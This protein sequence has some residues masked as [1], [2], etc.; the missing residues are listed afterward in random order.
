M[1]IALAYQIDQAHRRSFL[2]ER[3]L[4][5]E[6][7]RSEHL[8]HALLPSGIA[9]QLKETDDYIAEVVP[10]ATVAFADL[11]GFTALSERLTAQE[12]IKILT[13]M[14]STLDEA[15]A[16]H[17]LEKI[18][19]IGDAYMVS[20]GVADAVQQDARAVAAFALETVRIIQEYAHETGLP[21]DIRVGIA[22]GPL[23]SGVIGRSRPH[24]DLW[25][26]TVNRASRL[27]DS[28]PVG[29]IHIDMPTADRLRDGY[30]LGPCRS[31]RLYGIG[32]IETCL[33]L[34]PL[35]TP[36]PGSE[37]EPDRLAE[38][39]SVDRAQREL[40]RDEERATRR[41]ARSG[42]GRLLMLGPCQDSS[43]G[44]AVETTARTRRSWAGAALTRCRDGHRQRDDR[45]GRGFDRTP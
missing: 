27:E 16:R 6:R 39:R 32:E 35:E 19:T 42:R 9:E 12:L 28:A 38:V 4:A 11:V 37:V 23:V 33:L 29:S 43:N 18:K 14:F 44:G 26:T 3:A 21:L 40:P 22:S 5:D 7:D 2:L 30:R 10:D 8:L 36:G 24:F 25:G 17:G 41:F 15:A 45:N 13:E 1:S 34:G 20:A 31:T